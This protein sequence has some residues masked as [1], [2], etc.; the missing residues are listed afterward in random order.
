MLLVTL[1]N[2][3]EARQLAVDA[4][5]LGHRASNGATFV[6]A[7]AEAIGI[8]AAQL[9]LEEG[10]RTFD[11]RLDSFT[12]AAKDAYDRSYQRG[13]PTAPAIGGR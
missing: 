11:D 4:L 2:P 13:R 10:R 8:V 12:A 7:L 1:P 5:Q 6:L 3:A 9:D